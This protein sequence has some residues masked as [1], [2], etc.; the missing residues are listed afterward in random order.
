GYERND[1]FF[2]DY[3]DKKYNV[4]LRMSYNLFNKNIDSLEK[5]KSKLAL[6]ESAHS[7]DTV[8]RDLAESLKFSWQTYVLSQEKMKHLNK[9]VEY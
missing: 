1:I 9:H 6:A 8:K 4:M 3:S 7:I 5:E 2:D